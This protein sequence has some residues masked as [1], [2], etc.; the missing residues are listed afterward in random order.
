LILDDPQDFHATITGSGSGNLITSSDIID[1]K[2]MV[3]SAS[4]STTLDSTHTSVT[5][6]SGATAET[7]TL[8]SMTSTQTVIQVSEGGKTSSITLAGN[9]AGHSFV[10]SSD[11]SGGTQFHDPPDTTSNPVVSSVIMHDP[12]S[13]STETTV[14][15]A[16]NQML[17]GPAGDTFVFNFASVGNSTVTDFHPDTDLLQFKSSVFASAQDILNATHDD[18]HGNAVIAIDAQDSITLNGV[19]KAQLHAGDFHIV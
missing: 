11:G 9:Y 8:A 10:F 19:A 13:A 17:A 18:G 12:G 5:V 15:S 1:L 6:G 14:A 16:P 2:G 3:Y 4:G 7:L